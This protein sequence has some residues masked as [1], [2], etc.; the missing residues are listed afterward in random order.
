M[1]YY[2]DWEE[3]REELFYEPTPDQIND[4]NIHNDHQDNNEPE[5]ETIYCSNCDKPFTPDWD[6]D[7]C[8]PCAGAYARSH[9]H[10]L[11]IAQEEFEQDQYPDFVE[12]SYGE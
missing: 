12:R 1:G 10:P 11:D 7:M 8:N 6:D 5:D 9:P 2:D 3:G 4:W